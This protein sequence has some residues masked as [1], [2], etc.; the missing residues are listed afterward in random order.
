MI[1]TLRRKSWI[2][3]SQNV[4]VWI[5]VNARRVVVGKVDVSLRLKPAI[6]SE[7]PLSRLWLRVIAGLQAAVSAEN[8]IG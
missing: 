8:S 7:L 3:W 4:L 1:A 6:G 2:V 5:G